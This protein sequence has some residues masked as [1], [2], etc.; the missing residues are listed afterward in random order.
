MKASSI[1]GLVMAFLVATSAGAAERS[2]A[3]DQQ[4]LILI[5][6]ASAGG[7]GG[8]GI[9]R[10]SFPSPAACAA[11]AKILEQDTRGGFV[12]ARC[13]DTH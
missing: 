1:L 13:L 4:I 12:T 2:T 11:A 7:S 5:V 6:I 9:S 3:N 8:V 10:L